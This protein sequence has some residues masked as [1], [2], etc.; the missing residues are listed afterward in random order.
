[1]AKMKKMKLTQPEAMVVEFLRH[2]SK[3]L[4]YDPK[5]QWRATAITMVVARYDEA[6]DGI[7][8]KGACGCLGETL[9]TPY[10]ES[11]FRAGTIEHMGKAREFAQEVLDSYEREHGIEG[12]AATQMKGHLSLPFDATDDEVKAIVDAHDAKEEGRLQ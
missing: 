10:M 3:E 8:S 11:L 4:G 7:L 1:M 6:T 2:K 9:P 12:W 5:T